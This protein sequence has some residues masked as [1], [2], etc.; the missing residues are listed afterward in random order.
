MTSMTRD[1]VRFPS[2]D[3]ISVAWHYRGDNGSCIIMAGGTGV[4]KEP[5]TDR[6]ASAFQAAGFSV[7]AFDPR[8]LGESGGTPRQLVRVNEQVDDFGAAIAFARTLPE[9][10]PKRVAVWGFSL[11]GG[12][13]FRVAAR[14]P[15]LA[16]AIA[17]TP[18]ADGP[19]ITRNAM[20]SMTPGAALRLQTLALLDIVGRRFGRA[21]RLIPLAGPRGTVASLTTIDGAKGAAALNPDGAY[22]EWEQTIAAGSAM[23]LGFYRPGR[24]AAK[25]K[26]PLLVM[27]CDDDRSVLT[28]APAKAARKAPRGELVRLAGDH[29]APFTERHQDALDVQIAF[30]RTHVLSGEAASTTGAP[31]VAVA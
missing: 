21:P 4:T 23:R 26:C 31:S 12:H 2:G 17:Q 14:H 11:A 8:R 19:A 29:Y 9:V 10:D 24:H 16:A 20:R 5:G 7:V 22:G 15:D 3:T 27:V 6:F 28:A 18:L 25:V 30:L 13:V 1:K